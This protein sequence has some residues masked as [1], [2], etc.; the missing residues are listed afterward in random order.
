MAREFNTMVEDGSELEVA[1]SI[2]TLYQ[3]CIKSKTTLLESLRARAMNPIT[4]PIKGTIGSES[5]DDGNE[6]EEGDNNDEIVDE[7]N[8]TSVKL[9]GTI[10]VYEDSDTIEATTNHTIGRMNEY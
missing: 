7:F 3:E 6:E 10:P 4:L 1:K 8:D 5:S 9:V 2:W